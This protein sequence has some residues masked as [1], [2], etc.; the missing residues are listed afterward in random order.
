V[1]DSALLTSASVFSGGIVRTLKRRYREVLDYIEE[2]TT[3]CADVIL[4]NSG[5]SLECAIVV[6]VKNRISNM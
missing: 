2:V 5:T 1:Q 3:A 4:V 6:F